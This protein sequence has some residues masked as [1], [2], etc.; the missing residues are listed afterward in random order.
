L[1]YFSGI[2]GLRFVKF[3]APFQEQMES[4]AFGGAANALTLNINTNTIVKPS[5]KS[6]EST[7]GGLPHRAAYFLTT[8]R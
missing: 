2:A 1:S 3:A 8:G 5:M 4:G 6:M 7:T